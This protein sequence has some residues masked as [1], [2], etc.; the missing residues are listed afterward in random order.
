MV[1]GSSLASVSGDVDIVLANPPF[2]M[3]RQDRVYRSGGGMRGAKLSLE[4]AVESAKRLT[5]GGRLILY[6]GAAI[7]DGKDALHHAFEAQLPRLGCSLGYWEI[8]PDI[9]GEELC[10]PEYAQVERIAA[11]AAIVQKLP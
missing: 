8:D 5:P 9:F 11:I 7:V 4:W 1:Q 3:D 2:M 10:R 6:T